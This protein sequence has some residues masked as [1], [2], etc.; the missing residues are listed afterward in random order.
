MTRQ[1]KPLPDKGKRQYEDGMT[2]TPART[3]Q[4][5]DI[6]VVADVVR[7]ARAAKPGTRAQ[8]ILKRTREMHPGIEDNRIRAACGRAA[9][10]LLAQ[11]S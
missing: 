1:R 9:D 8:S 11:H 10:L 7:L 3:G 6:E 2:N 5:D 4:I